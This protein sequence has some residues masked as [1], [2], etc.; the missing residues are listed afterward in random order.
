M[1]P[2]KGDGRVHILPNRRHDDGQF[3]VIMAGDG[4]EFGL[5]RA[6]KARFGE[7]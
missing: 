7:H 3:D 4:F 6:H 1:R 2:F 5:V